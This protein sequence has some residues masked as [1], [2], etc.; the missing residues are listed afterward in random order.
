MNKTLLDITDTIIKRSLSTR[1]QYLEKIVK[2]K[3]KSSS[4][5][6]LGCSN[7]A[8]AMAPLDTEQKALY[9]EQK[10]LN[11]GIITAYNDMLAAHQP[12][13]TYPDKIKK[14]LLELNATAQVSAGVPAM[15]DGVTQNQVGMQL[16][17]FSRDTHCHE[18]GGRTFT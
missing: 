2:A 7:L 13:A 4:R 9:T 15:C 14:Y 16:S 18:Y 10:A 5:L 3:E 6:S 1:Q 12:Y 11:F 17:L 8:H